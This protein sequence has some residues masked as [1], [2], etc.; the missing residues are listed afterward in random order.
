MSG[1]GR[2]LLGPSPNVISTI[3]SAFLSIVFGV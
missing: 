3:R 2:T 1:K